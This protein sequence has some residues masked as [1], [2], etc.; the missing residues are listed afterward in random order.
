MPS[1][2][3][4]EVR[5]PAEGLDFDS[6]V[7]HFELSLLQQALVRSSGNKKQA[8]DLLRIKRTTFAA[9]L[10]SLQADGGTPE[11]VAYRPLPGSEQPDGSDKIL[12]W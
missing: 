12:D 8:A 6:V 2:L 9:K 7:S 4:P 1:P 5:L 11:A 10:R 3:A